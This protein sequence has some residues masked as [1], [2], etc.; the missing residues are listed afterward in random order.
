MGAAS[1]VEWYWRKVCSFSSELI[2][3]AV[4]WI[5]SKHNVNHECCVCKETKGISWYCLDSAQLCTS[6]HALHV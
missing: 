4:D 2:N 3:Y 5:I 6:S 1:W